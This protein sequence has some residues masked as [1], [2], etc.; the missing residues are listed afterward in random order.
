MTDQAPELLREAIKIGIRTFCESLGA[1]VVTISSDG[2]ERVYYSGIS[3]DALSV[4]AT[5]AALTRP[6]PAERPVPLGSTMQISDMHGVRT[7]KVI[8]AER[9]VPQVQEALE[10]FAKL[11]D[12]YDAAHRQKVQHYK[13]EGHP[14]PRPHSDGHRVSVSMGELRAAQ[15]AFAL[16]ARPSDAAVALAERIKILPAY[17][18]KEIRSCVYRVDL[19]DKTATKDKSVILIGAEHRDLLIAALYAIPH[20]E[21]VRED[22]REKSDG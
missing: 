15:R 9:P 17:T 19:G 7:A 4:A 8:T 5:M 16:T 22:R 20:E 11:A 2:I 14:E 13:D 12:Q 21:A 1:N 3:L 18:G 6:T 10:P